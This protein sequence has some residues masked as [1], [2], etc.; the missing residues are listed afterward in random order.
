MAAGRHLEKNG[1]DVI[2]PPTIIGYY[3]IWQA[4]A[5]WY[6]DNYTHIKIETGNKIPIWRPSVLR[7]RK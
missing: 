2:T 5:K 6:A 3:E 1:Y 4:D 7:N